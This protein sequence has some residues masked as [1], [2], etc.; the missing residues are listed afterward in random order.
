MP[1]WNSHQNSFGNCLNQFSVHEILNVA[2]AWQLQ[3]LAQLWF[4]HPW[5]SVLVQA[6]ISATSIQCQ[7]VLRFFTV[8]LQFF[9][10]SRFLS[11]ILSF[12]CL[13]IHPPASTHLLFLSS[14][15]YPLYCCFV[16]VQF[17]FNPSLL[18]VR[19]S[20]L[21]DLVA[22]MVTDRGNSKCRLIL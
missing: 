2:A 20:V 7:N 4:W 3:K 14:L 1:E 11:I 10:Q 16:Y 17:V 21:V 9:C 6:V 22:T 18:N 12:L 19:I 15:P 8:C 5:I 13:C